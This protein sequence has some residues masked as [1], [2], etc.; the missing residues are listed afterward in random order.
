MSGRVVLGDTMDSDHGELFL[1]VSSLMPFP[2]CRQSKL[3]DEGGI[4]PSY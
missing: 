4:S 2:Y 3:Q 1:K